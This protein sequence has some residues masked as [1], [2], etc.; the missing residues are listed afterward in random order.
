MNWL[1]KELDSFNTYSTKKEYLMKSANTSSWES[2]VSQKLLG[3]LGLGE[4]ALVTNSTRELVEFYWSK[5]ISY[6]CGHI[7]SPAKAN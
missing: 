3:K 2:T 1:E 6:S 5:R 4:G 7:D